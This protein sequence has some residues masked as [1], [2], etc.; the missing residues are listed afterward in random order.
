MTVTC[1]SQI[2]FVCLT[3]DLRDGG[4]AY[5]VQGQA[6]GRYPVRRLKNTCIT[7]IKVDEDGNGFMERYNDD[8]HLT[9]GMNAVQ[10]VDDVV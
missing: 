6:L 3:A 1:L 4:L 2:L 10:G 7:V 9:A 8:A 5:T